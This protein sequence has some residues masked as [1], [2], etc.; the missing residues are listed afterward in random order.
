MQILKKE[1]TSKDEEKPLPL[2]FHFLF[3]LATSECSTDPH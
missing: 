2:N 3:R 1:K